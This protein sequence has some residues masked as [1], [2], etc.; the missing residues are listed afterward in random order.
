MIH[1]IELIQSIHPDTIQSIL[2]L[3]ADADRKKRKIDPVEDYVELTARL[4][5]D[6][7]AGD[8]MDDVAQ[9]V[10]YADYDMTTK[11]SHS[12]VL[13]NGINH[14]KLIRI[15]S[16]AHQNQDKT[17]GVINC[18]F[19]AVLEMNPRTMLDHDDTYTIRLYHPT[20]EA[21]DCIA[22]NF[23]SWMSYVFGHDPRLESLCDFYEWD[24]HR[25]DY[26]C[27][28]RFGS[29]T[30]F[31]LFQ[32][33]THKTSKYSRTQKKRMQGIKTYDQSAAEGNKSYKSLFYDK[34][35]ECLKHYKEIDEPE[36]SCILLESVNV[37][38]MEQQCKKGRIATLQ[39]KYGFLDHKAWRY[40]REDIARDV[41]LDRYDK[42]VGDGDFYHREQAKDIIREK[43]PQKYMQDRLIQLIQLIAGKRH[44]DVAQRVF[45]SP[46]E[47]GDKFPL[48]HGTI[49]TFRERIKAIRSLGIH[50]VMIEDA[51]S[52]KFLRNPKHFILEST[53]A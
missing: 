15:T 50:P 6:A 24:C 38:R 33:L 52:V 17:R 39:K 41:L 10:I 35:D 32:K 37:V 13:G 22:R 26:T 44:I 48:A 34:H 40:L 47:E 8:Y 19:Y 42:M 9:N 27:N 43:V 31:E 4:R 11:H 51:C 36:R 20:T 5:K 45:T 46:A 12:A 25:I 21:N 18:S 30:E 7:V 28:M 53:E 29:D 3:M 2:Q 14:F 23:N 49:K 16:R 1:T